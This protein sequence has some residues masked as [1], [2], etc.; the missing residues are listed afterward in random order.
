MIAKSHQLQKHQLTLTLLAMVISIFT[1]VLNT[2]MAAE[3]NVSTNQLPVSLGLYLDHMEDISG[4]LDIKDVQQLESQWL[5]STQA[6]PTLGFSASA[7]WFAVT[8]TGEELKGTEL[9]IS[10]EAPTTDRIEFYIQQDNHAIESYL[11]GDTVPMSEQAMAYHIPIFPFSI[12]SDTNETRVYFRVNS[13]SGIELPIYLTTMQQFVKDQQSENAF[14]GGFFVFFLVC[15]TTCWVVY[16]FQRDRQF[17]GYTLFFG[18]SFMLI[19]TISGIGKVWFWGESAEL[20]NRLSYSS[21]AILIASFCLLGQSLNLTGKFR[22]RAVIILRFIAYSMV[23]TSLYFL[24]L[25]LEFI[26]GG[27]IQFLLSLGFVVALTVFIMA[28]VSAAQGSRVATYLV[29]AWGFLILAFLSLLVYKFNL[30]ERSSISALIGESFLALSGLALLLSLAEFVRSKNEAFAQINL[31]ARAKSDF[32]SNVS[33]EFL[34]PVHLI[35]ANSKRLMAVNANKLDQPTHQH[36]TTVI[37]QSEHL[38]NLINDLL[39]MAEIDSDSFEPQFELVEITQFLSDI[40]DVMTPAISEKGLTLETEFSSANLLVQTDKHRLHHVLINILSNA[41]KFT[42]KGSIVL[43]YKAIYF[44]RKLG[45]EIFVRD[46][47]KGV[48]D[49]FKSR[50]FQEFAHD[51]DYSESNPTTTGLGMVIVKRIVEKLG[52]EIQFESSKNSGSEFLLH[53]P[54]KM[55]KA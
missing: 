7:H 24:L 17:L 13:Q 35:L 40:K 32:L 47:G 43:G 15:F 51:E 8:I 16:Y 11:A 23:P 29:M 5:R 30:I 19:L 33:R 46:T 45:I 27:N 49:E 20:S 44:K 14:F 34:T 54:L 42:D 39:E 36:M 6:I 55:Y 10:V 28:T 53:L 41:I 52:G 18:S 1:A 21:G 38:H 22:D 31:D 9:A 25:P 3:V 50:M 2:A 26:S 4:E 37:K 48:S 12:D